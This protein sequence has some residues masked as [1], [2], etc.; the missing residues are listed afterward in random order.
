MLSDLFTGSSL[1]GWLPHIPGLSY[2]PSQTFLI[3]AV[4]SMIGAVILGRFTGNIGAL[5]FPLNYSVLFIAAV[6]SNYALSGLRVGLP[7]LPAPVLFTVCGM[8]W[9]GLSM[10]ALLRKE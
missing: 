5:T 3:S 8:T 4:F 7:G 10:L 1:F 6:L 2:L 9:G